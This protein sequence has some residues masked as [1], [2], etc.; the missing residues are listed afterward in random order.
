MPE[1]RFSP[2]RMAASA[3]RYDP[4]CASLGFASSAHVQGRAGLEIA[5][6]S[7]FAEQATS[8]T[9]FLSRG[10]TICERVLTA[11]AVRESARS[12]GVRTG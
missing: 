9:Y 2:L 4:A 3:Q 1:S 5:N 11:S 8:L 7:R 6:T 10:A 12:R